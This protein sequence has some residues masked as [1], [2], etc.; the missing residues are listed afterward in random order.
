MIF[1]RYIAAELRRRKAR[2]ILTSLGLAV[3]VAMVALVVALSRGLSDAQSQVLEPLTGVG[4]D[5]SVERQAG[6]SGSGA[7]ESYQLGGR[8]LPPSW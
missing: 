4:T 1:V 6:V 5:M 7:N 2:T 8:S 3:G